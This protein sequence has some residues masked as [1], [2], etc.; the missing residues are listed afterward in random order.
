M[1]AGV[2]TRWYAFLPLAAGAG[3]ASVLLAG[4]GSIRPS[5]AVSGWAFVAVTFSLAWQ[6]RASAVLD[7]RGEREFKH[8]DPVLPDVAV[9]LSMAA[10]AIAA[11]WYAFDVFPALGVFVWFSSGLLGWMLAGA[12]T[13]M[14]L[15]FLPHG[16]FVLATGAALSAG[17]VAD[18]Y[19]SR[20]PYAGIIVGAAA[21]IGA[22]CIAFWVRRVVDDIEAGR[23]SEGD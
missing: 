23:I 11:G 12:L 3:L 17:F 16:A 8:A 19:L 13:K 22:S 21:L 5:L 4:L 1:S 9:F 6:Q 10:A 7:E 15:G 2:R 18:R 20:V 14:P